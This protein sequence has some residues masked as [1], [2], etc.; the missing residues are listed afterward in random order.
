MLKISS[1]FPIPSSPLQC[2]HLS[3][4]HFKYLYSFNHF[5]INLPVCRPSLLLFATIVTFLNPSSRVQNNLCEVQTNHITCMLNIQT[6]NQESEWSCAPP[7]PLPTGRGLPQ[8]RKSRDWPHSTLYTLGLQGG[9]VARGSF[10]LSV[11]T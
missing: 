4:H 8:G 9:A 2:Y 5:L 6:E 7:H 3:S 1:I 11:S 10:G